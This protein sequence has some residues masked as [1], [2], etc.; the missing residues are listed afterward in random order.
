MPKIKQ[1]GG[2]SVYDHFYH[3]AEA[4]VSLTDSGLSICS[5]SLHNNAATNTYEN[6]INQWK[7]RILVGGSC[8]LSDSTFD[9]PLSREK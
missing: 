6:L 5:E 8:M 1:L 2:Q 7:N 9:L 3:F 4:L